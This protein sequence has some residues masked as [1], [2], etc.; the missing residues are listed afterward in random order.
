M[1]TH[2]KIRYVLVVWIAEIHAMTGA[3]AAGFTRGPGTVSSPVATSPSRASPVSPRSSRQAVPFAPQV[4]GGGHLHAQA[5]PAQKQ[6]APPPRRPP[7]PREEKPKGGEE[8]K[9]K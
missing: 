8:K 5:L 6:D 3:A 9:E 2:P 7:P 1:S 4:E